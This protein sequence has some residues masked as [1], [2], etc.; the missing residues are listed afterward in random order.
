VFT[1][2]FQTVRGFSRTVRLYLF[3][4]ALM[5]F[6]YD[7]GIYS[8][9]FN[10]YLLRL[11]L[12]P[13]IVGL[14]NSAGMLAFALSALPAGALG[15]RWGDRRMMVLG[16]C[17]MFGGSLSLTWAEYGPVEWRTAWL[18]LSYVVLN[19]GLA[20]YFVNSVP[21]LM[22]ITGP[23]E[24]TAAFS[25]QSA[26]ISLA[27]FLGSLIAGFLPGL[28]ALTLGLS[29]DQPA[30]YRIPLWLASVLFT[31][32][33]W[34]L[35]TSRPS[36][37]SAAEYPHATTT[38]VAGASRSV[39]WLIGGL[40]V[41]R[42]LLVCGSAV[43][44]T[45]FNVYMDNGLEIPTA[46]IGI[47]ISLGRL[48]AVPAALLTPIL[49][50]RLGNVQVT[51]LASLG[52]AL[53]LLPLAVLPVWYAATLGY[54]GAIALTSVRYPAFMVYTME[55]V[56]AKYRATL[57]GA[58]EMAVGLSFAALAFAGGLIITAGGYGPLFLLGAALNVIGTAALLFFAARLR[59]AKHYTPVLEP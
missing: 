7:G 24:R 48:S 21:Y 46:Q 54:V 49:A 17:A 37:A 15:E 38:S 39:W 53:F 56:P 44:M 20:F 4:T 18:V 47:A 40:T 13:A 2:Y 8:V 32:G 14:V 19:M 42:M 25:V 28:F 59:R 55:I 57:T 52:I 6:T 35:I 11:G 12:G 1:S 31:F 3:A 29:L 50:A 34:A 10:L 23:S 5:G 16:L 45:F 22:N 58:G 26:L 30:P 43:A 36:S 41:V 51:A 33:F 27:A 9:I